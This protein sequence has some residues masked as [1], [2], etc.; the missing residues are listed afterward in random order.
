[1]PVHRGVYRFLKLIV[2]LTL[3]LF[4]LVCIKWDFFLKQALELFA[5]IK[6]CFTFTQEKSCEFDKNWLTFL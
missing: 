6:I 2:S 4:S 1:M 5:E 3:T